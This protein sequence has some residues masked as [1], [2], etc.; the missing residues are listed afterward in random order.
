MNAKTVYERIDIYSDTGLAYD[1]FVSH[2]ALIEGMMFGASLTNVGKQMN[3]YNDPFDLPT[4]YRFG[5]SYV[6]ES[7]FF[8]KRVSLAG[9]VF[10]PKDTNGK[11][12]VGVE[13]KIIQEFTLRLGQKINYDLYGFTAGF[14]VVL[15]NF[16]LDYA[17]Q[18]MIIEGFDIGHKFSVKLVW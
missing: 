5:I 13:Y 1:F 3:L 10:I 6:P 9:D 2:K 4:A 15:N 12:H 17:Y 11:A 14:G 16:S 7:S 18:D 8:K